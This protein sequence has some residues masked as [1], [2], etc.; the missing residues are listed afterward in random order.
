MQQ[1]HS[2]D[3]GVVLIPN[4]VM[5]RE[6]IA[7]ARCIWSSLLMSDRS[8]A[9]ETDPLPVLPLLY[10]CQQSQPFALHQFCDVHGHVPGTNASG[11]RLLVGMGGDIHAH[12]IDEG[13]ATSV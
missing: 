5:W 1:L 6:F 7:Q 10:F 3:L 4:F 8:G 2:S 9:S 12:V 11:N 13:C